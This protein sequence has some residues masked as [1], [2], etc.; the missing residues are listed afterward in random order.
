[1]KGKYFLERK[2]G[3]RGKRK[4]RKDREDRDWEGRSIE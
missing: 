3:K 2:N 1:M 4:E